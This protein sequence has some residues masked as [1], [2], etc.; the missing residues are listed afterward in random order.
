VKRCSEKA[1]KGVM[2][3]GLKL[4]E[5]AYANVITRIPDTNSY[6]AD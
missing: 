3:I 2:S 6:S 4:K 5:F 1:V